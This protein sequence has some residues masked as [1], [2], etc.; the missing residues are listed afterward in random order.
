MQFSTVIDNLSWLRS[1]SLDDVARIS[2]ALLTPLIACIVAY[3]AWQQKQ[4]AH[5]KLIL[6][7]FDRRFRIYIEV[8]SILGQAMRDADLSSDR[9]LQF[10]N[11]VSDTTFLFNQEVEDYI[12]EIYKHGCNLSQFNYELREPEQGLMADK[13]KAIAAKVTA[14]LTW[15]SNQFVPARDLF[16]KYLDL[17][18]AKCH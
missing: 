8:K 6:D 11:S 18:K 4:T 10:L 9:L 17:S 7:L 15:L 14:E 3:T 1:F 13:R 2:A 5:Q 16:R 12:D